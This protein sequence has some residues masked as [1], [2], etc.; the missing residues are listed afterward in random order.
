MTLGMGCWGRAEDKIDLETMGLQAVLRPGVFE[1]VQGGC[2]GR[3]SM[4]EPQVSSAW[5]GKEAQEVDWEELSRK[6]RGSPEEVV[7]RKG[8]ATSM[9]QARTHPCDIRQ[10]SR[11]GQQV[12]RGHETV[13]SKFFNLSLAHKMDYGQRQVW[14]GS[15]AMHRYCLFWAP[16][17]CQMGKLYNLYWYIINNSNYISYTWYSN[18]SMQYDQ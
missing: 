18:Y 9:G 13:P 16:L 17:L 7:F 11:R 10:G 3:R 2:L 4:V 1:K 5:T 14:V 12:G 6:G 15:P 8:G